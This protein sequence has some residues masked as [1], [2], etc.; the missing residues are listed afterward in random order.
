M[1]DVAT[2]ISP[3]VPAPHKT[4]VGRPLVADTVSIFMFRVLETVTVPPLNPIL[5]I[6][7]VFGAINT[8]PNIEE[9]PIMNVAQE[10][11]PE[12]TLGGVG[13]VAP[14]P[15]VKDCNAALPVHLGTR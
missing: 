12:Y 9:V 1:F 5:E 6:L 10:K 11:V 7:P 3:L 2:F 4:P 13:N 8:S 15:P 14:P